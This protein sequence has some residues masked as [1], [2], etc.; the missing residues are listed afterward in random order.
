[1]QLLKLYKKNIN[2]IRIIT[3]K[4]SQYR[5]LFSLTLIALMTLLSRTAGSVILLV[6]LLSSCRFLRSKH[7]PRG[8]WHTMHSKSYRFALS[9]ELC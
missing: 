8:L 2:V 4:F 9:T 1:M 7:C 6:I 5:V 3:I